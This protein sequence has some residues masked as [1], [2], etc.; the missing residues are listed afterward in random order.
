MRPAPAPLI[1]R[2]ADTAARPAAEA[3]ALPGAFYVDP[4]LYSAELDQVLAAEWLCLGR[5]DEIP[6]PGDFF[7]LTVLGEPLLVVR[8]DDG[9]VR[10]LANICRHRGGPVA[11]GSGA[12]RRFTCPYHAWSFGRDGALLSAPRIDKARLR[13]E[14][15]ALP[16]Y[17]TE[18]W[19]GFIYVNIDGAAAPLAPRLEG[20]AAMLDRYDTAAMRH[21][22]TAEEV[23]PVNWKALVENFM[24]AYHLSVVH[25]D[26]LHAV[27]PTALARKFEGG[28]GYSG[29]HSNYPDSAPDRGQGAPGLTEAERRRSTLF[30]VFPAHVA[31]QSGSLLASYALLP[32]GPEQVRVRWTLSVY[33]DDLSKAEIAERAAL[34]SAVND[35]DRAKLTTTQTG[36]HSRHSAAGPLAP[37]DYEGVIAD[38][39]RYLA[40]RLTGGAD[41]TAAVKTTAM[42]T[43][44]AEAEA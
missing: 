6:A 5:A 38:F 16:A 28:P 23:W 35:Q 3:R 9:A 4:A 8:G 33:G 20:L 32:E 24:E 31:S 41:P 40:G 26:T 21:V 1:Q 39:H 2:L 22:H 42:Q 44:A 37:P 17:R 19:R 43:T 25:K 15:C 34:W 7:T 14:D 29:Y 10:V 12:A 36:F 30:S 18:I 11:S 13:P 27:T